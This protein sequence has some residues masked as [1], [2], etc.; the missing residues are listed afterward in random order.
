MPT[1]IPPFHGNADFNAQHSPMGAFASF[2][3]GTFNRRGGL[4][5]QVGKPGN[6]DLYVGVKDGRRA[7]PGPIRCLP[8]FRSGS[9]GGAGAADFQ[10]EQAAGPAEQNV[11]PKVVPIAKA[12]LARHYGWATDRWAADGFTFTVYTPFGEIP[13]PARAEG[14]RMR[15]ALLPAVVAELT[16]DN[17]H[18]SGPRTAV[19]AMNFNEPGWLP[20][21][22]VG[23][24]RRGFSLRGQMGVVGT[25]IDAGQNGTS[26]NGHGSTAESAPDL[27]C[28]W[29]P[30]QG[31]AEPVPHLLGSC[32]GLCVEVPAGQRRTLRVALGWYLGDVVTTGHQGRYLYTRYFTGLADVLAA[33]LDRGDPA[34]ACTA[35]DRQLLDS[36]LSVDQQFQ[37]A[38]ATRSY[39]GS[40]QLLDVGGQPYWVVN[41]GEYCMM[42][43][44]DLSVDQ[45]F[46]ELDRNPW[47]VRNLLDTFVR[48][49]SYVD[50]LKGPGGRTLPGGLSFT[51]D[52][53]AHNNFSPHGHSSYELPELNAVCFSYMTAEQLANWV[54]MAATYVT[55]TGDANWARQN[56]HVLLACLDSLRNRGGDSGIPEFDS[57]RCGAAGAEITTYDSLDHS[58][59]QT[60]NNL[61]MGVKFWASFRGLATV[62]A[63]LGG[64][65]WLDARGKALA[66]AERA[67]ETLCRQAGPDGVI[68]A[69][70]E[71]DNT[72]YHSR[73]LPAA[74]GLLY[75]AMWGEHVASE[76]PA[77]YAALRKHTLALLADPQRRN[78]F[79]DGGIKLSSTSNNSW[80]SKIALFQHVARVVLK[81]E[82]EP[83]IA[84]LLAAADAAH[85]VWQT[86][87]SGYWA[88]SDQFVSGRAMGSRYYPRVVTAALWMSAAV[89]RPQ[90]VEVTADVVRA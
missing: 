33:A 83:G 6:Q 25:V 35:I 3:C 79:A 36:G 82:A 45:M 42:N 78:L 62:F 87:G 8:F 46:W 23:A 90:P 11:A 68:P 53:G 41:E 28:R 40:T 84:D 51:H 61:Y 63:R 49:Y 16:V 88:C 69:V 50:G 22:G 60:R 59:A 44:L 43:T 52:Q 4:A 66:L 15:D 58:L 71:P 37:I 14:T 17:T 74:E 38:H 5:A 13:D 29:S 65:A 80:M 54:L 27:F 26:H 47:V 10:V 30:D 21:D 12:D 72:G 85:V 81:L 18:G 24:G 64:P 1:P 73:I 89:R 19:F 20:L 9:G 32:P 39:Y 75:P 67:A 76:A 56:G 55:S 7:D 2:T 70:F 48:H 77:L 86:D 57:T 31:L 34:R